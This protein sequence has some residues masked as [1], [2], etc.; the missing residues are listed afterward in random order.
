MYSIAETSMFVR[1][2]IELPAG[3]KLTTLEFREGWNFV[4]GKNPWL[5]E[6]K[7]LKRGW[8]FIRIVDG[9]LRSGVGET[10]QAAIGNALSLALRQASPHFNT[11]EVSQ[12]EW[13]QY[14]WFFLARVTVKPYRIQQDEMM[15]VPD[16]TLSASSTLRPRLLPHDSAALFPDFTSAMPLLREMLVLSRS[17]QKRIQ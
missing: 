11:V 12:I 17:A 13:T 6:K 5:L 4:S 3:L 2:Q 14:P 15:P 16:E 8:K 1:A 7:I 10:P 9:W